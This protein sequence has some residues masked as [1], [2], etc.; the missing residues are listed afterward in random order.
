[1][2]GRRKTIVN[3][4]FGIML[5]LASV[6]MYTLPMFMEVKKDFTE[7][8]YIPLIPLV[9]GWVLY[10]KPELF[11]SLSKDAIEKATNKKTEQ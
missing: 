10:S 4:I 3:K 7:Q 9:L 5:M 6:C 2:T 1:M 8:W 11:T